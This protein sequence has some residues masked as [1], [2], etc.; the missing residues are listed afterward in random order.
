MILIDI[1]KLITKDISR[2]KFSSFLT[3]FAISLGIM[4]IYIIILLSTS[5]E[6]SIY[7]QFNQLGS[8][9]IYITS[10]ENSFA[11]T[12]FTKG[13]TDSDLKI[14]SSKPFVEK[15]FPY[16]MR[17]VQIKYGREYEKA[18]V[19]GSYLDKSLFDS[20]NLELQEGRY[21]KKNEKYAVV[22]GPYAAKNLF[23]KKILVGSNLYI[24]NTKF[25]V[26]GILKSVGDPQ[27]DS[28]IYVNIDTIRSIFKD[29][30]KIGFMDV[31]IVKGYNI[32][33]A[34]NNLK[35][36]LDNKFGKDNMKIVTPN[37]LINQMGLI[38]N[39]VKYTLGGIAVISLII[40][41]LG[42]INTMFVIVVEKTKDIGIMKSIGAKN[43]HI[44]F[45][46][47]LYSMIFGF[48]GS[49]LGIIFGSIISYFFS[50][51]IIEM[52]FSFF[53]ISI[54]YFLIFF[55]LFFGILI[56]FIAGFLPSWRASK[57]N[58]LDSLRR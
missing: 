17:T 45:M 35:I 39:I 13:L 44:L 12:T 18:E 32:T 14:I 16:Y 42:I 27:D 5:F 29:Y 19:M 23:D 46:F 8:N 37:Q 30:K 25:K 9:R 41:A 20:Y 4:S 28:D 6:S 2:K 24:N 51:V 54:N 36:L 57:M 53:K 40:G 31:L 11:Q 52:G 21:P 33:L 3:L 15:V 47:I 56:G 10:S 1:F 38:I 55:L 58:I 34:K 49:V 7:Q 22:I 26:V 43:W 50:K 48:L